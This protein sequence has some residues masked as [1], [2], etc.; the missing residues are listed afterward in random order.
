MTAICYPCTPDWQYGTGIRTP[1]TPFP[2][3]DTGPKRDSY[4]PVF[5][6]YLLD[7]NNNPA[8]IASLQIPKTTNWRLTMKGWNRLLLTVITLLSLT[9]TC[10]PLLARGGG[11]GGG[12]GGRGGNGD[13]RGDGFSADR[14]TMGIQ[15]ENRQRNQ[16]RLTVQQRSQVRACQDSTERMRVRIREMARLTSGQAFQ[17]GNLEKK[18]LSLRQEFQQLER[19]QAQFAA[20]LSSRDQDRLRERLQAMEQDRERLRTCLR[21][22]EGELTRPNPDP[23]RLRTTV[24]EMEQATER[25]QKQYAQIN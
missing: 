10:S 19:A 11:G 2:P 12:G 7:K 25:W 17:A 14:G 16:N 8:Q 5:V 24:L 18:R 22:M 1:T 4:H 3:Q 15:G 6:I 21:D 20:G 13:G 9:L 23:S